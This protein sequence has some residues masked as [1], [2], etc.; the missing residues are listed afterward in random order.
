MYHLYLSPYKYI[1][2]EENSYIMYNP[3]IINR[4]PVEHSSDC[5]NW[6]QPDDEPMDDRATCCV[7]RCLSV[8]HACARVVRRARAC[9]ASTHVIALGVCALCV[10]RR[11][12]KRSG[13]RVHHHALDEIWDI[14]VPLASVEYIYIRTG[15][16][17]E[18]DG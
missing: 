12:W 2:F 11:A 18:F 1:A 13:R 5:P 9:A 17:C 10:L 7:C 16:V 15:R 14:V 3:F 4:K 6:N 8:S